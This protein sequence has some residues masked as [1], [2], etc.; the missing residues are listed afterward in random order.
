M[1]YRDV[2]AAK[3]REAAARRALEAVFAGVPEERIPAEVVLA[4]ML[5][6]GGGDASDEG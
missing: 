5:D 6:G 2:I 4:E 3:A 1:Q